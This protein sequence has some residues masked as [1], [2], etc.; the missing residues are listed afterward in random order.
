MC[1]NLQYELVYFQELHNEQEYY[2]PAIHKAGAALVSTITSYCIV[3]LAV[4]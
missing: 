3:K 2:R 1:E 4:D